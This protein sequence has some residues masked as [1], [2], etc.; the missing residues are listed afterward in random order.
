MLTCAKQ[1]RGEKKRKRGSGGPSFEDHVTKKRRA[2]GTRKG[3][4]PHQNSFTEQVFEDAVKG[5]GY[6]KMEKGKLRLGPEDGWKNFSALLPLA[7]L[8]AASCKNI[9]LNIGKMVK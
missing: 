7:G 8:Q 1:K 2:L 9:G 5:L 4:E 3:G 6:G